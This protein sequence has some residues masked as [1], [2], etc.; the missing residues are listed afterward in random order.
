MTSIASA[1]PASMPRHA[2]PSWIRLVVIQTSLI[3]RSGRWL[4]LIGG[5][6]ALYV[7]ALFG[8]ALGS[9]AGPLANDDRVL[10]QWTLSC[11][12]LVAVWPSLL[13][14]GEPLGR[15]HYHWSLPVSRGAHD[16]AR[17]VAGGLWVGL[18]LAMLTVGQ[19]VSI[20]PL[21]WTTDGK[22]LS[23]MIEIAVGMLTLY[24]V[25]SVVPLVT[26]RPARWFF[27]VLTVYALLWAPMSFATAPTWMF[28]T[29]GAP[30][31][32]RYGLFWA[33]VGTGSSGDAREEIDSHTITTSPGS[34][35]VSTVTI[36]DSTPQ[37][38]ARGG[39]APQTELLEFPGPHW[40]WGASVVWLVGS[41]GA[42][43]IISARRRER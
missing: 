37:A 22:S 5:A 35:I 6:V 34:K 26:A 7:L 9:G 32:G 43:L 28:R 13:W 39:V 3:A 42:M 4:E 24:C 12:V 27:G 38:L 41:I 33:T 25:A 36:T 2:R 31:V 29:W 23:D 30:I 21:A 18:L 19:Y 20:F 15:R 14:R 17:V 40:R 10:G 1:T 8:P 16:L 11:M